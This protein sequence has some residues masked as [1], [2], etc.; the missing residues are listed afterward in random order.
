MAA[1]AGYCARNC[2][3]IRLNALVKSRVRNYR[4]LLR[5]GVFLVRFFFPGKYEIGRPFYICKLDFNNRLIDQELIAISVRMLTKD[6][7]LSAA[8]SPLAP[9]PAIAAFLASWWREDNCGLPC[10]DELEARGRPES[11]WIV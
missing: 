4:V 2:A 7:A 1:G 9:L 6:D 11:V 10:A 3:D 8:A 5:L